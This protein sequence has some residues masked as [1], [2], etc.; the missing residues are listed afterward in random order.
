MFI[1]EIDAVGMR[2]ASLGGAG[3]CAG[4]QRPCGSQSFEDY[5]FF[6]PWGS[7]TPTGDLILETRAWRERLFAERAEAALGASRRC[8]PSPPSGSSASCSPA[9]W[10]AM[11]GGQALNQLLV[12]MD[13]IGEAPFMRRFFTNRVNTLLDAMYFIPRKIGSVSLRLP[14]PQADDRAGVLHRRHQRADRPA[15]PGADPPGPD[16]PPRLV[17][18]ADARGPQGHLQP[19]PGEGRSRARPRHRPPPR[20]A[21]ADH[22]RLR[23]RR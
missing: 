21:G 2:R 22:Q 4:S 13:G 20:R 18:H 6:G 17:P 1:D 10:A 11:G 16:G 19:V 3:G 8:S 15:R 9:G 7:L 5:C 12:Q 14:A 23:A